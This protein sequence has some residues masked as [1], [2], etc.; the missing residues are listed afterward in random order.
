M[1]VSPNYPFYK[2]FYRYDAIFHPPANASQKH[3]QFKYIDSDYKT[4]VDSDSSYPILKNEYSLFGL[5]ALR[6]AALV[7]LGIG[8]AIIHSVRA[9]FIG[10]ELSKAYFFLSLRGLEAMCAGAIYFV[11]QSFG[12]YLMEEAH[13]HLRLYNEV[14]IE[15]LEQFELTIVKYLNHV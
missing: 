5:S 6:G 15:R 8:L 14:Y 11:N 2:P 13:I 9:P 10:S 12:S 1:D 3:L 7:I 4:Y